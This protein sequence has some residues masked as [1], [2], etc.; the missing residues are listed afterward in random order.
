LRKG[1][2]RRFAKG[3]GVSQIAFHRKSYVAHV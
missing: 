2:R 3:K 1:L